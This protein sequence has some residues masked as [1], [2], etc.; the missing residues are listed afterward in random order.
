V[1]VGAGKR[2]AV[3]SLEV[4]GKDEPKPSVGKV[5]H[6]NVGDLCIVPLMVGVTRNTPVHGLY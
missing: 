1:A 3:R 5:I 6:A 4:Q 2:L